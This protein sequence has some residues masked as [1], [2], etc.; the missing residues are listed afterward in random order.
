[1]NLHALGELHGAIFTILALII[2]YTDHQGYLY[3]RGK[4][5]LLSEGFVRWSHRL[6]WIGLVLM[7]ATGLI[8][9]LPSWEYRLQDPTFYV[10]MG[11]VLVL[12]MNSFAIGALSKRAT[13][14]PFAEL[15]IEDRRTL[16]VSG[17]LSFIGWVGA[18]CIGL[19]L[20]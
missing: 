1:M 11:F 18:A 7:I 13:T 10:K 16:M 6:V 20:L 5:K 14:T 2:I 19:L 3:F 4:K 12:I 17:A 15:H 8:L 9:T